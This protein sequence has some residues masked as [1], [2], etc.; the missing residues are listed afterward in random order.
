M[1]RTATIHRKTNETDMRLKLNLDGHGKAT[2]PPASAF[3]ITC[4]TSSRAME[5]ST[6]SIAA[7]GDL[8][9]DQHHTVEDAGIALGEAVLKARWRQ[10][11]HPARRIFCNAHGRI[12]RGRRDRSERPTTLCCQRKHL[13]RNCVGDF[14]TEL[15]EDFFQGSRKPH[16]PTYIYTPSMA[17]PLIIRSKRSSKLSRVPCVSRFRAT[18]RFGNVLPALK[19]CYEHSNATAVTTAHHPPS[20]ITAPAIVPSVERALHRLGASIRTGSSRRNRSP[21][22]RRS[23][24]PASVISPL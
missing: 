5:R 21:K 20:S 6:C 11:R 19:V 18:R 3:S 1:P 2:S 16:A 24:S 14:Q 17:A 23:F 13:T 22:P 12:P 8:D 15:V 7:R 9:V 10:T 4:S